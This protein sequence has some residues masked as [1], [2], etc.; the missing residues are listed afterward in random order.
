[1]SHRDDLSA[2][3][4]RRLG[5]RSEVAAKANRPRSVKSRQANRPEQ[6]RQGSRATRARISYGAKNL[7]TDL[8]KAYK[9]QF[10]QS[11][12]GGVDNAVSSFQRTMNNIVDD[13][14]RTL[15]KN[16]ATER[17]LME[18]I[19]NPAAPVAQEDTS[20]GFMDYALGI[21]KNLP[22]VGPL[23]GG[24]GSPVGNVISETQ[25]MNDEPGAPFW[26]GL[27]EDFS[28]SPVGRGLDILSRPVY[29]VSEALDRSL[30]AGYGADGQGKDNLLNS[31]DDLAEGFAA[32][33]SGQEKTGPGDVWQRMR[34]N[35]E[36]AGFEEL[37]NLQESNPNL[38]RWIDRGV[39]FAGE[40]AFDPLTYISGGSVGILRNTG[41]QLTEGTARAAVRESVDSVARNFYDDVVSTMGGMR[42]RPSQ[43]ALAARAAQTAED[44]MEKNL[45]E[46][47]GGAHAGWAKTG[48]DRTAMSLAN[49]VTEAVRQDIFRSFDNRMGKVRSAL[50]SGGNLPI[51]SWKAHL[52]QSP[53][54]DE[55]LDL[56]E[57]TFASRAK[58]RIYQTRDQLIGSLTKGDIPVLEQAARKVREN[59]APQ[60]SQYVTDEVFKN[61]RDLY[62]NT[63]GLKVRGKT[64]PIKTF[65][66]A[67]A[68]AKEKLPQDFLNSAEDVANAMSYERNFPGRISLM[69]Q[70]NKSV[71]IKAHETF[72]DSL[73]NVARNFTREQDEL[74]Q[75]ALENDPTVGPLTPEL[76]A[77]RKYLRDVYDQIWAEKKA[78]GIVPENAPYADDFAYVFNKGGKQE[79]RADFKDRRKK[80]VHTTKN[81]TGRYKTTQAELDGLK[82]VKG[83]HE[84]LLNYHLKHIRDKTRALFLKDLMENYGFSGKKLARSEETARKVHPVPKSKLPV[85]MRRIANEQNVT[86]Y[87]PDEQWKM[88]D[89]YLKISGWNPA[90]KGQLLRSYNRITNIIKYLSTVPR[91]GFHIRNMIGDYMMGMLDNVPSRTYPE[92]FEK[93]MR[94]QAG[95]SP[96]FRISDSMSK[97]WDQMVALYDTH[98]NTGFFDTEIPLGG[99]TPSSGQKVRNAQKRLAT[100]VRKASDKRE[101]FGRFAHFL[102]AF[103]QEVNRLSK[104]IKDPVRLEQK[105]L[106]AAVWRVNHYK[107][108]YGALT[109]FE[110]KVKL[111]FPFYTFA[112]KAAPTLLQAMFLNPKWLGRGNRFME[113]NDGSAADS[114]NYYFA[115]DYVK[116]MGYAFLTNE[117]EPLYMT[118][119]VTPMAALNN[120]DFTNASQ[121]FQSVTQQSNP[122]LQIPFEQA[123]GER[124]F[125]QRQAGSFPDYM[126]N[127]FSI[128]GQLAEQI[129]TPGDEELWLQ[130]L[131]ESFTGAGIPVRRFTEEQQDFGMRNLEDRLI[132]DPFSDFNRQNNGFRI[133]Q[134]NRVDGT[135][136][137][138]ENVATGVVVAETTNPTEALQIAKRFAG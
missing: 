134:S 30:E 86:F 83:A 82:P 91:A 125:D 36:I 97:T 101:D 16:V 110:R 75:R 65:G 93:Y 24:K 108:D 41:E 68:Y 127:K 66:K 43:D 79:V 81:T 64:L 115:P 57:K 100:G 94:K 104:T 130:L 95:G 9:R 27:M 135:S 137:R 35:S 5:R 96:S 18:A 2:E 109:A 73:S 133:Y 46:I 6:I 89:T 72:R 40:V 76:E 92:V 26:K 53:E 122:L 42:Y 126:L 69:T 118:A 129:N 107:F 59:Y 50:E 132:Q 14:T 4:Q 29:G 99:R 138:V 39:G 38:T 49:Q 13:V 61:A 12:T 8:K 15:Q 21:G 44:W 84:A 63:I 123:L 31:F 87:L 113:Y 62:Y 22:G 58:P 51:R 120:L 10:G 117:E 45:L 33:I 19:E 85:D 23:I 103:R 90:D 1:M 88:F 78:L 106:D 60:L 102:A 80:E 3:F 124:V 17:A 52:A 105:A 56:V 70:A 121:F 25:A 98:A 77:G 114:F 119:D 34:Q 136:F 37:R 128:P 116:D 67:Y 47:S 7:P 74:L 11:A 131:N 28:R 112:R 55:V 32:G 48:S 111:A 71:G 54:L 20:P